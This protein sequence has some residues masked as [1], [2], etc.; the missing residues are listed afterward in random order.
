MA[1]AAAGIADPRVYDPREVVSAYQPIVELSSGEVVAAE[2][3]ARW[4]RLGV[5]P[6]TA[7]EAA[8]R[9]G[10]VG[11]LDAACQ[12]A[13][14]CG[15]SGSALPAG[16]RLFV[17]VEPG[18][19]VDALTEE[20]GCSVVAE[21]TERALLDDPAGLLAAV[22]RLRAAGCGIALD[23]VGA[24]P[25]SLALLPFV[26]PDVVKLDVSLVQ[27]WPRGDQARILTAVAAHS[28]RSGATVLAEGIET[29]RHRDQALA[30]GAT[31]GQGWFFA[32]PGPLGAWPDVRRPVPLLAHV[33]RTAGTPFDLVDP[34]RLRD[35]SKG[36]L[37]GISRHLEQQGLGLETPPLVLG[38]FQQAQQFTAATGRRYAALA[39]RCPLVVALG[40]GLGSEPAPGV[41]GAGLTVDD[42]LRGEW[43]VLVVGPHYAG[44]L[45]ARDLGDGG[46]EMERRFR[47]VLTHDPAL[48]VPAARLLLERVSP[49]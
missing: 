3:L 23:D 43:T 42:R 33:D 38:A 20:P 16:F 7:F 44:G 1:V 29:A 49:A 27:Q 14:L 35:G 21:I 25:D 30:L 13:A 22:R 36:L 37:L 31:L 40:V 46:P 15:A 24:V 48:V 5:R 32:R 26:A 45:I 19:P 39:K 9:A 41:R 18:A 34:A 17:N 10:R 6:D 47:F 11:E 28:E 12:R 8:R 2:A 4:P